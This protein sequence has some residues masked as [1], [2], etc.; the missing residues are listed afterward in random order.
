MVDCFVAVNFTMLRDVGQPRTQSEIVV[1]LWA[2]GGK[3]IL[4]VLDVDSNHPAAFTAAD[5]AGLEAV[6]ALFSDWNVFCHRLK[7]S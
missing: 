2:A 3:D 6:C 5:Q 4:G 1:P 7:M